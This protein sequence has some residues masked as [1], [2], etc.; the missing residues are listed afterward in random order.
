M[1]RRAIQGVRGR[2][3]REVG[4]DLEYPF[5]VAQEPHVREFGDGNDAE[6]LSELQASV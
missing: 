5:F 4:E 6:A 1:C 3:E 2:S